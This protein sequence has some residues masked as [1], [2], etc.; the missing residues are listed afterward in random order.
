MNDDDV[1]LRFAS[2]SFSIIISILF[3]NIFVKKEEKIRD[4]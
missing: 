3:F 2:F 4:F 1:G